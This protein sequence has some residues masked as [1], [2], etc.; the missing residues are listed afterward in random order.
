MKYLI[1]GLGNTG[2]EYHQ[3]RHNIGFMVVDHIAEEYKAV[4]TLKRHAHVAEVK[5]K[6]R[7]LILVKP[8]TY[9]N[10][11]GKAVQYWMQEEKIP[12]EN[13]LIITD[14]LALPFG[15]LR[16]RM[17]G[18]AGGHN[19]LTHIE[20]TVASQGYTRLRMGV[21][22]EFAKGQQVDYVLGLFSAEQQKEMPDVLKRAQDGV[23]AFATI[24]V[25]RAMNAVN[26]K[27]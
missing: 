6:G 13:V 20:E 24:G 19:G 10:L 23:I 12:L 15:T 22:S 8:T 2:A 9:M 4:F 27:K 1:I 26:T 7:T 16:M 25:E 18:S 5:V 11:S 21:G 14:D 17:K 3:T